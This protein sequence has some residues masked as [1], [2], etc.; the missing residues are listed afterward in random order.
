MKIEQQIAKRTTHYIAIALALMAILSLPMLI[1]HPRQ[2]LAAAN[3]DGCE[4]QA[5]LGGVA[6]GGIPAVQSAC[7]NCRNNTGLRWG[8]L[9]ISNA[10]GGGPG[11]ALVLAN[12]EVGGRDRTAT[13]DIHGMVY[14]CGH[15]TEVPYQVTAV[16]TDL[17]DSSGSSI[18][19]ITYQSRSIPRGYTQTQ[20]EW[21]GGGSLGGNT[22]TDLDT[23]FSSSDSTCTDLSNGAKDCR[24][25]VQVYRCFNISGQGCG[26]DP[27]EVRAIIN[28]T[29]NDENKN[30]FY[31]K[32]TVEI[33]EQGSDISGYSATS[34]ADGS[35][36]VEISTDEANV[37]VNFK[38]ELFYE[39]TNPFGAN[40]TVQAPSV[41]WKI[42]TKS[43]TESGD[44]WANKDWQDKRGAT[45]TWTSPSGKESQN[46]GAT[47]GNDTV[48]VQFAAAD[49]GK[50]KRVCRRV[51][52][53][54]KYVDFVVNGL[55]G[56]GYNWI[57]EG[58][59]N[60]AN[61]QACAYITYMGS[62]ENG[63]DPLA[64]AN[65]G[66]GAS[67]GSEYAMLA[68]EDATLAISGAANGVK[69]RRLIGKE[70]VVFNHGA[71]ISYDASL[72]AGAAR[73]K[74]TALCNLFW[75]RNPQPLACSR[76]TRYT[77]DYADRAE[78]GASGSDT[79]S[80]TAT[81]AVPDDIGQKYC[82][83][84]GYKFRYFYGIKANGASSVTYTSE[85]AKD[86]TYVAQPAC[87]TIAKRPTTAFWNGSL[88]VSSQDNQGYSIIMSLAK[89]HLIS[90]LGPTLGYMTPAGSTQLENAEGIPVAGDSRN[91]YGSW[92]EYLVAS[93][94]KMDKSKAIAS[95][96][97][98][99]NGTGLTS[100]NDA[101]CNN[102]TSP[103]S[104]NSPLTI[105]NVGCNLAG[106]GSNLSSS[107]FR[108]RLT[109]YLEK[110][111]SD[112]AAG[113]T[114]I[115]DSN[116]DITISSASGSYVNNSAND[117]TNYNVR[118]LPQT[119]IFANNVK[120]KSDV[121]RI[122]AW[123]IAKGEVNTCVDYA[124]GT[125]GGTGTTSDG[126]GNAGNTCTQQLVFN[127]P[128]VAGSMK[129]NRTFGADSQ[130]QMSRGLATN[131]ATGY[132]TRQSSAEVFN[133][134]AD[135]YLWGYAQAS[136]YGSSYNETYSRELAPRY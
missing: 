57:V 90:G 35:A 80:E 23:F 91:L 30:R 60:A 126:V 1:A 18:P 8:A 26:S 42:R 6:V 37:T 13:F 134:R 34:A 36:R 51:R 132:S 105:S 103:W 113:V 133:L 101:V 38:H 106:A 46:S 2:A 122:D 9:W 127:G 4:E 102:A 25:T 115:G 66:L 96:A 98:I 72:V 135:S 61:S 7:T 50:T 21:S 86:Y 53:E 40:D 68:G 48:T 32:S 82:N 49:S 29:T 73:F 43:G 69:T 99:S 17:R 110:V 44:A 77:V 55:A 19:G 47:I 125:A 54:K 63:K 41:D 31:S 64:Q 24:R 107:A 92:S 27:S 76:L 112:P 62:D 16:D 28:D 108:T 70:A 84:F 104:T 39:V 15:N 59:K 87:R 67:A 120:V 123:I 95:G 111:G 79:T 14:G 94:G 75:G 117:D 81:V 3:A 20:Y 88:L 85:P 97:S 78:N 89:R 109:A 10:A 131:G 12:R 119:I 83:S 65:V 114:V 118:S 52:Y 100:T 121:T 129:L 128:V 5:V 22:I 56:A 71:G 130:A 45:G 136:R 93:T 58:G 124:E 116:T 33:P 11:Q 74:G